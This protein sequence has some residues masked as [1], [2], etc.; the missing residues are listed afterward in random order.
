MFNLV[1]FVFFGSSSLVWI[2]SYGFTDLNLTLSSNP[3]IL[4]FITWTQHLVYFN[5]PLSLKVYLLLLILLFFSYFFV[6]FFSKKFENNFPWRW[7]LIIGLIFTFAYPFLS[8]DSFKY[9]FAAKM[10]VKYHL[11]PHTH[12]PNFISGDPWLRFMRWV[13]TPSP[14]GPIFTLITIPA[15]ILGFGKFVPSLFILKLFNFFW[16]S[17]IVIFIGKISVKFGYSPKQIV[18]NQLFF[19]FNP[20]ALIEGLA[21]AHNDIPMMA[22][23]LV[24]FYLF[25]KSKYYFSLLTFKSALLV[26]LSVGIKYITIVFLPLYLI[27]KKIKPDS[28]LNF[29]LLMF[30]LIPVLYYTQFQPWYIIWTITLISIHHSL[31]LKSLVAVYS[32]GGMLRYL[33]FIATGLWQASLFRFDLLTFGPLFIGLVGYLGVYILKKLPFSML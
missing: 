3:Q 23:F 29:V 17:I 25:L 24:G 19:A 14:Y 7:F 26:L 12:S 11:N 27:R 20:L 8:Y 9:L 16:Y 18:F 22:L 15:Y 4:R 5:R 33:P 28:F 32:L 2:Y 30:F 10:V 21:N 31:K 13:H 1:F 6:L